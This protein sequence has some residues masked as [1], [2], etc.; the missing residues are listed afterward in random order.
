MNKRPKRRKFK[1][2]PYTLDYIENERIYII[3]FKDAKGIHRRVEVSEKVYKAFDRFE[4][5]DLSEMNEYDNHIEHSVI[6]DNKIERLAINKPLSLEDE[7]IRNSTFEELKIAIEMLPEIQRRRIKK[8][9]FQDKTEHEI[10]EEE[11]TTQPSVHIILE[12]AKENLKKI[13]KNLR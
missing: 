3:S 1:D 13:L 6:Y 9:Y 11:G 5:D 10:A 8:Y 7:I 2:N 12:R 4:L